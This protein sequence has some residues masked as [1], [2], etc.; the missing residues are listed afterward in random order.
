MT[1]KIYNQSG[2]WLAVIGTYLMG[3][4]KDI[5]IAIWEFIK[6]QFKIWPKEGVKGMDLLNLKKKWYWGNFWIYIKWCIKVVIYLI[7]F[8]FGGPIVILAGIIYLYSKLGTKLTER[9]NKNS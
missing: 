7:L 8:C 4:V 9:T 2:G 5:L 6:S 3:I 1:K